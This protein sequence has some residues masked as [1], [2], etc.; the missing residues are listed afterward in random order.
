MQ[1]GF[2]QWADAYCGS[3]SMLGTENKWIMNQ[4]NPR[5]PEGSV[6][7]R[8]ALRVLWHFTWLCFTDGAFI[9][10]LKANLDGVAYY[11]KG[12]CHPFIGLA[13]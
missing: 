11:C 10:K 8:K 2:N 12:M 13:A 6:L 7:V 3:G 4:T 5:L 9:Y 1:Y